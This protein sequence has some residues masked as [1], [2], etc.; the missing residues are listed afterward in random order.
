MKLALGIVCLAAGALSQAATPTYHKDVAP[1]LNRRCVTCH[2][3]GEAAPMPLRTY[4]EVRPWSKAI[5]QAVVLRKMPVWLADPH[6]GKF[7]NDRS[8]SQSDIDTIAAWVD[9]GTPE[10]KPNP[11]AV[12]VRFTDGWNI[13][14]PDAVLEMG[15]DFPV[16]AQGAIEYQHFLV[17]THFT[18]DRWVR[19]IEMRPGNRAVVHHAAIFIRPPGSRWMADLKADEAYGTKN[20]RWFINRTMDDELLGFYVPGGMPYTLASG[21]AKLVK[22]GSDLVF[23]VHYTANGKAGV[24]RSRLGLVFSKEPPRERVHSMTIVNTR[25]QIPPGVADF[26]FQ[27]SFTMPA[28]VTLVGMNPHMHLRGKSFEFKAVFPDGHSD[29]LLRVPNYNFYW[30]L[31]YF[32]AQ[33]LPL[34]A[35]TRIECNARYDNSPNNPFNPDPK[36][37]VRWGDQSWEEMLVGTVELAIPPSMDIKDLYPKTAA[38]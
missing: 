15:L 2:R 13:G 33:Q 7:L 16:P 3:P 25:L 9:A 17:P 14:Q 20:Q 36:A 32:L 22:A 8:L 4:Q 21:Q 1:I 34:P 38:R 37:E 35:G 18:E 28:D 10:G 12:P 30:Q 11:D 5:K 6:Y 29:V 27:A 24:D 19:A 23:Q 26:P 31:Y